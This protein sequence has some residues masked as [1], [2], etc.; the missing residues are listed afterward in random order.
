MIKWATIWPCKM[1]I[2]KDYK[3]IQQSHRIHHGNKDELEGGCDCKSNN[4]KRCENLERY[5]PRRCAFIIAICKSD[6]ITRPHAWKLHR[7]LQIY[8]LAR[9]Y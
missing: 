5:L 3:S 9:K 8:R 1:N 6:Y 4:F 7:K 2:D